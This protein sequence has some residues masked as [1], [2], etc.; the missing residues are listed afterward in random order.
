MEKFTV[1][2][3][4]GAET[5]EVVV[6]RDGSFIIGKNGPY[7]IRKEPINQGDYGWNE[8]SIVDR[9]NK[10]LMT[11]HVINGKYTFGQL[12]DT[13]IYRAAAQALWD[14]VVDGRTDGSLLS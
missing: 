2:R 9:N 7:T 11:G 4:Y 13:N 8:V 5:A 12:T 3:G 14:L 10:V 6:N 1:S